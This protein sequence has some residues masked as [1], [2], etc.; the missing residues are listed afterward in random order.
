MGHH[1]PKTP[2]LGEKLRGIRKR[3]GLT[4]NELVERLGLEAD[5][6][7]ERISKYER[8][9]LEPPIYVLIAYSDLAK[10]PLDV[11]LRPEYDIPDEIPAPKR[12]LDLS[13]SSS[14]RQKGGKA[15]KRTS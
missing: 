15:G 1:R 8:A 9:V 13:G 5:F 6:D 11:L 10:I 4:Q 14:K 12:Y 7:Q 2:R 3:M